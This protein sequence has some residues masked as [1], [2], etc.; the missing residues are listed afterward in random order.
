MLF[1][2][3]FFYINYAR[4][5]TRYNLK[6]AENLASFILSNLNEARCPSHSLGT[7]H[8]DISQCITTRLL[9]SSLRSSLLHPSI[10][11]PPPR[12]LSLGA[13]ICGFVCS[14]R[15]LPVIPSACTLPVRLPLR[16]LI[17]SRPYSSE[18]AVSQDV[19][20]FPKPQKPSGSKVGSST[21][22]SKGAHSSQ[23][24]RE[25][26][27]DST[28]P[29]PPE[30]D[31][32][33]RAEIVDDPDKNSPSDCPNA[34]EKIVIDDRLIEKLMDD[35]FFKDLMGEDLEGIDIH[36]RDERGRKLPD[37]SPT[38]KT[39]KEMDEYGK[40]LEKGLKDAIDKAKERGLPTDI[41]SPADLFQV[42]GMDDLA[43]QF[44]QEFKDD[45]DDLD[46][47]DEV[48]DIEEQLGKDKHRGKKGKK[49]S[50]KLFDSEEQASNFADEMLNSI[51]KEYGL[52]AESMLISIMGTAAKHLPKGLRKQ[53]LEEME[54]YIRTPGNAYLRKVYPE[55]LKRMNRLRHF[56]RRRRMTKI[57]R[58][59]IA[60]ANL[61]EHVLDA[62]DRQPVDASRAKIVRSRR[63]K[64]SAKAAKAATIDGLELK[65]LEKQVIA[66]GRSFDRR[67]DEKTGND[68][69]PSDMMKTM[70]AG[71]LPTVDDLLTK[72][73][74]NPETILEAMKE[75]RLPDITGVLGEDMESEDFVDWQAMHEGVEPRRAGK[76]PEKDQPP[77][78]YEK[79]KVKTTDSDEDIDPR[80]DAEPSLDAIDP[81]FK[82]AIRI[83]HTKFQNAQRSKV[84]DFKQQAH[85]CCDAGEARQVQRLPD[86]LHVEAVLSSA[87]GRIHP[88]PNPSADVG[89]SSGWFSTRN[90]TIP[91]ACTTSST[92]PRT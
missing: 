41:D 44:R 57:G 87:R 16:P 36:E 90:L 79:D 22:S 24:A 65:K 88:G 49:F 32:Y 74:L 56:W 48:D 43:E 67:M 20:S 33:R 40:D 26:Q 7:C 55:A 25:S 61:D 92:W 82:R 13:A 89:T 78:F 28:G 91:G 60:T 34:Q 84:I 75:G 1:S 71:G 37:D 64:R 5:E 52:D 70:E 80:S 59:T 81:E 6:G 31:T 8:V 69:N 11:M 9:R 54:Q 21:S 83:D 51:D 77:Q 35:D 27:K 47:V 68:M 86:S 19:P 17:R 72:D 63:A 3:T 12:R 76:Q 23:P 66:M 30:N 46:D 85:R 42:L 10:P 73:D 53:F 14:P 18:E 58:K 4:Q 45:P 15:K 62:K 50:A 38:Y 2:C 29:E 39:L